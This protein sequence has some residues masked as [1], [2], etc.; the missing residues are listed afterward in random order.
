[1]L[2]GQGH[3]LNNYSQVTTAPLTMLYILKQLYNRTIRHFIGVEIVYT[4]NFIFTSNRLG[5]NIDSL[6]VKHN[7]V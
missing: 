4:T 6:T 1:M 2:V 3:V 5:Y 7:N